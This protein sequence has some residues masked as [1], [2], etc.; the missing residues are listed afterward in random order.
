MRASAVNAKTPP[1]A[2]LK[3]LTRQ[4]DEAFEE[5][6]RLSGLN[7]PPTNFYQ[8]FL[9]KVMGGIES[10]AGVVWIRTPQ[11]FLQLQTQ[12]NLDKVGLDTTRGARQ[13]HN[14]L[15]RFAFQS[16]KH[17]MLEPTQQ[18]PVGEGQQVENKT[19][20]LILLAP[21]LI[22]DN[23]AVG[24]LEIFQEVAWDT[25][26]HPTYLNYAIQ[27]AGYAS[28]YVRQTTNRQA[29][30]QEQVWAQLEAFS[31]SIHSSLNPTEVA[32]QI[33][34]DGR[35]LIGCDRVSIAVRHGNKPKV[36]AV[37]G[38]DV[39]EKA[40]QHI[41][42]MRKLFEAVIDWGEKLV[43]RGTK[44]E[45]LPPQVL[46]ALDNHLA[47]S[48][49]KLLVLAPL[50]DERE[51]PKT[52]DPNSKDPQKK[53]RSAILMECYDPPADVEPMISRLDVVAN[54]AAS[55]LY[56]A[57]E[58]KRIPLRYMWLPLAK[59][60][61]GLGGKARFW[62]WFTMIA[63]IAFIASMILIPYPLKLDAKGQL[64]PVERVYV[65]PPHVGRIDAFKV[66]PGDNIPPDTA[67]V[68]MFD[69]EL[70]K[71]LQ[72]LS[73]RIQSANKKIFALEY[74]FKEFNLDRVKQKELEKDKLIEIASRDAFI[75]QLEAKKT[76]YN[77]EAGRF[78]YFTLKAPMF[79]PNRAQTGSPLW[80]VLSAD[81]RENLTYKT[82][83]PTDP[84]LRLGNK[85]GAWEIELKIPQKHIGQVRKAF[86]PNPDPEAKLDVDLLVTSVPTH[87]YRGWLY[88]KHIGG[89]AIPNRTDQNESEPVV[90]AYVRVNE[91]EMPPEYKIPEELLVT[92]VE[93]HAKVRCGDHAMGYSLFYGLWEFLYR[94]V[95]FFF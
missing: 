83:Q 55:A 8:E 40:G 78:G 50:R 11:G 29:A 13:H 45:S 26:I 23:K 21:I 54:H 57:A 82:V 15:L 30:T 61:D 58:M 43:Y 48:N 66:N 38:A 28:Q 92:G 35:R 63:M 42:A 56:N 64:V 62:V 19:Q 94:N 91:P 74:Q 37:S 53:P 9:T 59:L 77:C 49:A 46:E 52:K 69:A 75:A 7:L 12:I 24:I 1:D 84:V 33:A 88:M 14:E 68:S 4:I 70:G 60:Q 2:A 47:E 73:G 90:V 32:Y 34:N 95:V 67:L 5:V 80:T 3:R 27:M 17:L 71:E 51:N 20:Y 72:E 85:R 10:T 93:V 16:N 39:V 65:Y 6:A 81:Y 76:I 79:P 87:T 36:E 86:G 31:R 41:R 89:E 18:V 25:R 44:D 22:D